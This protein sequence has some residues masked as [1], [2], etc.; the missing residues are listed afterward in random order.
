MFRHPGLGGA[1]HT[2]QQQGAVGGQRGDGD[3]HQPAVTD[4]FGGDGETAVQGT[5]QQIHRYRSRRQ[6]PV[7]RPRV[8]V[9][10]GQYVQF[11]GELLFRVFS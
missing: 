1:G 11:L 4:V 3:F 7:G 10:L 6:M 9:G 2:Q 8:P 5:A